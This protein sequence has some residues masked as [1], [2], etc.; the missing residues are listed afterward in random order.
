M[1]KWGECVSLKNVNGAWCKE[2]EYKF[3]LVPLRPLY[4]LEQE[5]WLYELHEHGMGVIV[6]SPLPK[7]VVDLFCNKHKIVGVSLNTLPLHKAIKQ[8]LIYKG[9]NPSTT[10]M[11][12]QNAREWITAY[13]LG[14]SVNLLKRR[15]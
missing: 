14:I 11:L 13:R 3:L 12:A 9:L 5:K 6:Y 7:E 2:R 8:E 15:G 4:A 10:G 1:R